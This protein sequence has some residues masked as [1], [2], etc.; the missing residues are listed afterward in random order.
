MSLPRHLI[1]ALTYGVIAIAVA[2]TL[3][4]SIPSIGKW[5]AIAI[6]A[7]IL[8]FGAVLHETYSR[9]LLE[10]N[11]RLELDRL[12]AGREKV[13]AELS[14]ARAEIQSI[15]HHLHSGTGS[16][17]ALDRVQ[18]EVRVLQSLVSRFTGRRAGPTILERGPLLDQPGAPEIEANALSE[19]DLTALLEDAIRRDRIDMAL[20]PIVSLPQRKTRYYEALCRIRTDDGSHIPAG[21]F[22]DLAERL[23]LVTAIDNVLLFRCVQL[24]RDAVRR[25]R[26]VGFFANVSVDT[27]RDADFME[28]F[29]EFVS[30][31]PELASRLVFEVSAADFR[32]AGKTLWPPLER[33]A[34]FGF[35]FSVDKVDTLASL[36]VDTLEQRFVRFVKID[37][38]TLIAET[39]DAGSAAGLIAI[40]QRLEESAIDLIVDRIETEPAL[41]ELLDLPVDFGQGLLFGEPRTS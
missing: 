30:G 31:A 3:P 28:Q 15:R 33:L 17:A 23:G 12:A 10:R 26:L 41:V 22:I 6:G 37:A 24:I 14:L 32:H 18:D 20:Q 29:V 5:T 25:H 35:R 4:Y 40:K 21:R 11:F 9:Q 27:L 13:M 1:L 16:D 36:D 38:A 7:L 2:L 8:L 39:R 19:D 34:A